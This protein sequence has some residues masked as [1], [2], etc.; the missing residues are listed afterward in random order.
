MTPNPPIDITSLSAELANSVPGLSQIQAEDILRDELARREAADIIDRSLYGEQIVDAV[1]LLDI[2]SY[3]T[4]ALIGIAAGFLAAY[5]S[6]TR[7]LSWI[8]SMGVAICVGMAASLI[9]Y[10]IFAVVSARR[11]VQGGV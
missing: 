9:T 11:N 4:T 1:S 3:P 6:A 2:L 5:W 7:G 8:G 10:F